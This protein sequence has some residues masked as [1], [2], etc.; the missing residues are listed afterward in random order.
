VNFSG[1]LLVAARGSAFFVSHR[2]IGSANGNRTRRLAV[3][4]SPVRSKWL[5][6]QY[7]WYSGMLRNT[8]TNRRRHNAVTT[9]WSAERPAAA[10]ALKIPPSNLRVSVILHARRE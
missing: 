9:R 6:S 5:C 2:R 10:I 8:A 7:V 1:S 4:L 3:Q